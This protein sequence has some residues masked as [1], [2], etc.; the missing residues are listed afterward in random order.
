MRWGTYRG[1]PKSGHFEWLG[2]GG[3]DSRRPGT[4]GWITMQVQKLTSPN[5][6]LQVCLDVQHFCCTENERLLVCTD[7]PFIY[8]SL[9]VTSLKKFTSP[10]HWL[11]NSFITAPILWFLN[12]TLS[13]VLMPEWFVR[14]VIKEQPTVSLNTTFNTRVKWMVQMVFC[15]SYLHWNSHWHLLL[16][17]L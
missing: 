11:C 14:P 1:K 4:M 3:E 2:E 12:A 10:S 9:N 5:V 8:S 16:L 7:T 13:Y 6:T 15:Y 17:Y